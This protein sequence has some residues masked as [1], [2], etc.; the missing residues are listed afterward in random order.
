VTRRREIAQVRAF[1]ADL[2]GKVVAARPLP[3]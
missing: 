3:Q 1:A 2:K